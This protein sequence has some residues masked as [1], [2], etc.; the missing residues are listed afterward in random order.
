MSKYFDIILLARKICRLVHAIAKSQ[1]RFEVVCAYTGTR[2]HTHVIL[3]MGYVCFAGYC[4][5]MYGSCVLFV[6][7]LNIE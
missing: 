6:L 4:V 3:I 2:A 5:K 1:E 7:I